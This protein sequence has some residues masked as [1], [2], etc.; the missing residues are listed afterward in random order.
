MMGVES[1]GDI[2]LGRLFGC[3]VVG[4]AVLVPSSSFC[5]LLGGAM[6]GF[7]MEDVRQDFCSS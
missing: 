4:F 6:I 7:M 3:D 1:D 5:S 2:I